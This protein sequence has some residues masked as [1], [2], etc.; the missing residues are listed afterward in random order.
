M[1]NKKCFFDKK[2]CLEEKNLSLYVMTEGEMKVQKCCMNCLSKLQNSISSTENN[3]KVSL[4]EAKNEKYCL[5]C[6]ITLNDILKG[7]RIGCPL[8]YYYFE[9]EIYFLINFYHKASFHKGK[10]P[11]N[12][13]KSVLLHNILKDL[14]EKLNDSDECEKKKILSLIEKLNSY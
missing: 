5:S 7:A 1:K 14:N 11:E 6:K 13:N 12:N 9:E 10:I 8:C 4:E 2:E 3:D